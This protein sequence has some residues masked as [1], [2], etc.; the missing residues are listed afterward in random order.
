MHATQA[1]GLALWGLACLV[2]LL[3][4]AF[5]LEG[6]SRMVYNSVPAEGPVGSRAEQLA[7][8]SP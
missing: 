6:M 3:A 4:F 2:G 8:A 1:Y 7:R 5:S